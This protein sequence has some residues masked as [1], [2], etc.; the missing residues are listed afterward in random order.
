M[1]GPD[2]GRE[3]LW[4]KLSKNR[5]KTLKKWNR[6]HRKVEQIDWANCMDRT[7]FGAELIW[8]KLQNY[9]PQRITFVLKFVVEENILWVLQN[10]DLINN[11]DIGHWTRRRKV[12]WF[13]G[14]V[15]K[16]F[17]HYT[18]KCACISWPEL[19]EGPQRLK[20]LLRP[21]RDTGT[22]QSSTEKV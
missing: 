4:S 21:P 1:G 19:P 20:W 3:L 18:L 8:S 13:C 6:K 9:K 12:Q 7:D 14:R 2:F 16:H 5:F 10:C 11:V 15:A 22:S 17:L